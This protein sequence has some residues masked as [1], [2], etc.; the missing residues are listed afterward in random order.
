[1]NS[2]PIASMSF[3]LEQLVEQL[4]ELQPPLKF[5]KDQSVRY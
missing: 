5:I 2:I 4:E 1:M 3:S